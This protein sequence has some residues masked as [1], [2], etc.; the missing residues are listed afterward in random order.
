MN[1]TD[2]SISHQI[3]YYVEN[4]SFPSINLP[5][6][7]TFTPDLNSFKIKHSQNMIYLQNSCYMPNK[8]QFHDFLTLKKEMFVIEPDRSRKLRKSGM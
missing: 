7:I 3:V 4:I 1:N 6:L 2:A 5:Q 8:E